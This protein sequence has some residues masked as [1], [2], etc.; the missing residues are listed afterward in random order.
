MQIA[1]SSSGGYRAHMTDDLTGDDQE[2]P[3]W[4]TKITFLR[5]RKHTH[6]EATNL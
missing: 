2:I 3:N 6:T 5:Q 4:L 1:S